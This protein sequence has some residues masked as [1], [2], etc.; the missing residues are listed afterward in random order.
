[1]YRIDMIKRKAKIFFSDG[2]SLTGSFFV[3]PRTSSH[4]GSQLVSELLNAENSYLPF[5]SDDSNIILVRKESL[6]MIVLERNE[7][8][9]SSPYRK[10]IAVHV[11]F[12]SGH[13]E[14]GMVY[15]DLPESSTRLSD[16]LNH[17]NEFFPLDV[18]GKNCL[19][20]SR[21]VKMVKPGPSE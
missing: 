2:S 9:T 20:N 15:T 6:T 19:M 10:Q 12:I 11:C 16:F 3:S 13:S 7:L 8:N 18:D 4:S 17:H 5:E 1:M 21:F 14:N